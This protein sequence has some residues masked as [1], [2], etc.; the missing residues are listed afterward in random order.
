[1]Q[2]GTCVTFGIVFSVE[3]L[4][5]CACKWC[6][7]AFW[8]MW[9]ATQAVSGLRTHVDRKEGHVNGKWGCLWE[10]EE[11]G[12]RTHDL[13]PEAPGPP[14]LTNNQESKVLNCS[15]RKSKKTTAASKGGEAR[16]GK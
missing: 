10:R 11:K 9:M 14:P 8:G 1:M 13:Q 2:G 3:L 15:R 5:K 16:G 6:S 4:Q 7:K 12:A